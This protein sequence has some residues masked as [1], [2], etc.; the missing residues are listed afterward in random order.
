M[1]LQDAQNKFRFG[2]T[3]FCVMP[4]HIHLLIKPAEGQNLSVIMRWIKT[5]SAV[6]WN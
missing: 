4:T 2:L 1:V 6:R 3:N 5:R